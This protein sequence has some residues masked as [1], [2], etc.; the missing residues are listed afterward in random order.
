[1]SHVFL[2]L[3]PCLRQLVVF[4]LMDT[5]LSQGDLQ[6]NLARLFLHCQRNPREQLKNLVF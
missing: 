6:F 4:T 5:V 2:A 3:P 1:M